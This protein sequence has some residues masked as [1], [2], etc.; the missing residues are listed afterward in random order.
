M[1]KTPYE[2]RLDVLKLAQELLNTKHQSDYNVW[3]VAGQ[4]GLPK[5][6]TPTAPTAQEVLSTASTLYE[7]VNKK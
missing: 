1:S 4:G 3:Y 5:G 6:T 2:V 7:F